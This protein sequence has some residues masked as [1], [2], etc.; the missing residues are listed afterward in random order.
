VQKHCARN[1]L[2]PKAISPGAMAR[3]ESFDWP[4]NVRELENTMYRAVLIANS[5]SIDAEDIIFTRHQG[6][7]LASRSYAERVAQ[8][9]PPPPPRDPPLEAPAAPALPVPVEVA[10]PAASS[11]PAEDARP[12]GIGAFVGR[13]IAEI[14]EQLIKATLEHCYGNRTRAATILGISIQTLRN[15]LERYGA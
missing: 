4:G 5:A 10:A 13:S 1:A 8:V 15:K 14:E 2:P 3:L 9:A 7:A 6:A 12:G 11:A